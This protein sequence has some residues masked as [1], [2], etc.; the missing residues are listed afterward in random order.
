MLTIY[1]C[2]L[3]PCGPRPVFHDSMIIPFQG[4]LLWRSVPSGILSNPYSRKFERLFLLRIARIDF[5]WTFQILYCLQIKRDLNNFSCNPLKPISS[6]HECDKHLSSDLSCQAHYLFK[7]GWI[8][9][10]M[11]WVNSSL[12]S[13]R[14][15]S[16]KMCRKY[17]TL[18]RSRRNLILLRILEWS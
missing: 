7:N 9:R 18:L 15:L 3:L 11:K 1:T 8:T 10:A 12:V 2:R 6:V 13:V 16:H 5:V 4:H 17:S 14:F